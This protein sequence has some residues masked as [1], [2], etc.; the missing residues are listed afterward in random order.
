MTAAMIAITPVRRLA[1]HTLV[2][3]ILFVLIGGAAIL[4]H[5]AIVFIEYSGVSQLVI[6]T[7]HAVELLLFASDTLSFVVFI[8]IQTYVFLRE[9]LSTGAAHGPTI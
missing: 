6:S 9:I 4:L 2:G 7:L 8:V 5:H 1:I 3:T